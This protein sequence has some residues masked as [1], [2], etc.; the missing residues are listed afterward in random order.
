MSSGSQGRAS[1]LKSLEW[2]GVRSS[3]PDE[4]RRA[5]AEF[6]RYLRPGDVVAMHGALGSGKT[7]FVKG[8]AEGLGLEAEISSPTFALIHEYGRPP[9]LYHMDCYRE[10]ALER[11]RQLGLSEYFQ[12]RA[13]S[14]IEWAEAITPLLPEGTIHLNFTFGTDE[15]SRTVEVQR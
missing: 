9:Q 10:T 11:W 4:T 13:I 6:A 5:G 15:S 2:Q 14:V 8:I 1:R 12:D 7:T 3:H